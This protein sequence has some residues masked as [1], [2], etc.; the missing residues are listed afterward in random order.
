MVPTRVTQI[1]FDPKDA[2]TVWA[3]VEIGSVYRSRDS[4]ETWE[5]KDSGL[6]SGDVHGLAV[7]ALHDGSKRVFATTNRGLLLSEDD[8]E[9]WRLQEIPAPWPYTRAVVP[10]ADGSGVVFLCNGNGPPGNDGFLL[11]SRDHGATWENARL[12]GDV[13]SSAWCVAVDPSDPMLVFCCTNLGEVFRSA[14]GGESWTRLPHVCGE[15][16]ALHWHSLPAGMRKQ[17]HAVTRPVRKAA[18]LGWVTA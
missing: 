8:G 5:R 11:R 17:P 15:I 1:L 6:V 12:P 13:S 3:S 2:G 9:S 4:G 10:R 7:V 18:E 14:N 16:R